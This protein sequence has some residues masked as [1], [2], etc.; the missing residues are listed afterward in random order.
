M[1]FRISNPH[2]SHK[3]GIDRILERSKNALICRL[4][5]TTKIYKEVMPILPL[6]Y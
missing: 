1:I 2:L 5:K 3:C 6:V 4:I